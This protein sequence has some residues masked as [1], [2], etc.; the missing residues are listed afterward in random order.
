MFP[1]YGK[2][3]PRNFFFFSTQHFPI[4]LKHVFWRV[5]QKKKNEIRIPRQPSWPRPHLHGRALRPGTLPDNF[6]F[7]LFIFVC[8]KSDSLIKKPT[9]KSLRTE[10][11]TRTAVGSGGKPSL[12][13]EGK[14]KLK[15]KITGLGER[16][17]E[18]SLAL[19]INFFVLAC[20][21]IF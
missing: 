3:L 16:K 7:I 2:Q 19:E 10:P 1:L 21:V 15:K 12:V 8:G 6:F 4:T 11:S 20:P 13:W 18:S 9:R 5:W 14:K 17:W